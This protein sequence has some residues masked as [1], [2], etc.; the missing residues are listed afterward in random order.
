MKS[1]KWL[2]VIIVFSVYALIALVGSLVFP[3]SIFLFEDLDILEVAGNITSFF[4]ELGVPVLF[5]IINIL[6]SPLYLMSINAI[7]L[8]VLLP[9]VVMPLTCMLSITYFKK[10]GV[11]TWIGFI[12]H[13]ASV[14]IT[15]LVQCSQIYKAFRGSSFMLPEKGF[16]IIGAGYVLAG[17]VMYLVAM[18]AAKKNKD[19][20]KSKAY[21]YVKLAIFNVVLLLLFAAIDFASF[22]DVSGLLLIITPITFF[23]FVG[24]ILPIYAKNRGVNKWICLG[25]LGVMF[26]VIAI[27]LFAVRL[28]TPKLTLIVITVPLI[29]S[30]VTFFISTLITFLFNLKPRA[31]SGNELLA[32]ADAP[33]ETITDSPAEQIVD[34]TGE[35][36]EDPTESV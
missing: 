28:F 20:E 8:S 31:K 14:I 10:S 4:K 5:D 36:S 27:I 3:V 26:I 21:R 24:F 25:A 32:G 34:A 1:K 19:V 12:L 23:S 2:S 13:A 17:V 11:N 7:V 29:A 9:V 33:I 6:L 30:V 15:A 22:F 35:Q 18:Y 16:Y